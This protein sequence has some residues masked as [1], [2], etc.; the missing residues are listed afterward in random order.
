MSDANWSRELHLLRSRGISLAPGLT[1]AELAAAEARF[2][3]RFPPHLR[4]FLAIVLPLGDFPD[5]RDLDSPE[6]QRML[7]WPFEGMRF[8]IEHDA[9]WWPAWGE[10]PSNVRRAVELARTRVA[11]AP[12]LI[13]MF[14][15]R[16]L[17]AEPLEAGNPV[18]SVWQTDI[19]Y[20]GRDLRGYLANEF[21]GAR[22]FPNLD[23]VRPIRFWSDVIAANDSA[24]P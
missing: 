4:S 6:L 9:F 14:G 16:Y 13:P 19:I 24:A 15:H 1:P 7:A 18:L 23:E 17:P 12:A 20:Y 11:E 2:D 8:D 22:E 5:W 10:R 21:G 3:F